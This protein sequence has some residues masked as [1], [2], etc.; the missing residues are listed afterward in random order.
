MAWRVF[1]F[2]GVFGIFIVELREESKLRQSSD[3]RTNESNSEIKRSLAEQPEKQSTAIEVD[4]VHPRSPSPLEIDSVSVDANSG[5]AQKN[6]LQDPKKK[7]NS[8]IIEPISAIK[9]E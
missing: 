5:N 3:T 4:A 7:L 8:L 6:T 1:L 9:Q 2:L